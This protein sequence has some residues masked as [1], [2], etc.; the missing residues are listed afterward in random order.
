M[1]V[2]DGATVYS[3]LR[4]RSE[5]FNQLSNQIWL[6]ILPESRSGMSCLHRGRPAPLEDQKL[7]KLPL[8][9]CPA[10]KGLDNS[11]LRILKINYEKKLPS[12]KGFTRSPCSESLFFDNDFNCIN[13]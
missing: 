9:N 5:L 4:G 6:Q 2:A 3:T 7:P 11:S 8:E 13:A 12:K 1:R 10:Y